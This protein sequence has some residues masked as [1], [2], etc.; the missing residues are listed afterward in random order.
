MADALM[1]MKDAPRSRILVF[2]GEWS[3][4]VSGP[5]PVEAPLAVK[6]ASSFRGRYYADVVGGDY[7]SSCVT[8]PSGFL[9]LPAD[10]SS[11]N[12]AKT[13]GE[14]LSVCADEDVAAVVREAV[15]REGVVLRAGIESTCDPKTQEQAAKALGVVNGNDEHTDNWSDR[16]DPA[17]DWLHECVEVV[18]KSLQEQGYV[19]VQLAQ[20]PTND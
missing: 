18:L 20:E 4:D 19:I 16:S 17:V 9:P 2:D 15:K 10:A 14:W 6:D 11:A 7:Y 8:S 3:G 13:A 1:K 5:E 12:V